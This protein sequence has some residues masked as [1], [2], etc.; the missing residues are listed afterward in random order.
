MET[1]TFAHLTDFH[2]SADGLPWADTTLP[3]HLLAR[4]VE[5]LNARGDLDFVLIT[6]DVLDLATPDEL[7]RAR[8]LLAGLTVP[9]HFIPG[10]HDGFIHESSPG[11]LPPAEAVSG[12]DPRMSEPPP[13]AQHGR[14]RR[15]VAEGVVLI[16]LDSR[17][18]DDW[19]GLV[20]TQQLHWL[21][22]Q[23]DRSR[24]A[25]LVIVAVHHPLHPMAPVD[26]RPWWSNFI[27][28]NGG[29]VQALLNRYPN[30]RLVL[31]GHHHAHHIKRHGETLHVFTAPLT[32]YPCEYRII[33][34]TPGGD[35]WQARVET[36]SAAGEAE[37]KA[38]RDDLLEGRS[39]QRFNPDDPSMWAV[40]VEGLARDRR[41][42]GQL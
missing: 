9:W 3:E 28:D 15:D 5:A 32:L 25:D 27:C 16:G 10:N 12:L 23:L 18:A 37:R 31:G 29:E 21:Q 11:A 20:E 2:L 17:L 22:T 41:Y 39:A 7:H 34:L 24:A 6:G 1:L 8:D 19:N 26:T 14:W 33:R 40:F 13:D 30:V 35:G 38:A 36:H 42:E 4:T